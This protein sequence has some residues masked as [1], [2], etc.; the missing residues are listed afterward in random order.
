TQSS[1]GSDDG[2]WDSFA[3]D[4]IAAQIGHDPYGAA[5]AHNAD[6]NSNGVIEAEEAFNYALSVQNPLDSPVFDES[7]EAGGD[8]TLGQHYAVWWLWCWIILPILNKY[9]EK[10]PPPPPDPERIYELIQEITPELQKFLVPALDRTAADLRKK[11][12]PKAE[13]IVR[14][15]FERG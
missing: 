5:L 1:W 14:A 6:Q 2:N 3:R 8:I 9:V 4:W 13:K 12:G 15:A 7:S 10:F 11:V